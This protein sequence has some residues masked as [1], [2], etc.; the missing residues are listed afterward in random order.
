MD[1][2]W[3]DEG[4]VQQ[5]NI[6][7]GYVWRY[8]YNNRN[9]PAQGLLIDASNNLIW[10]ADYAFDALGNRGSETPTLTA[11]ALPPR[12]WPSS[13]M[14]KTATPADL[15][16][17]GTSLPAVFTLDAVDAFFAKIEPGDSSTMV[18]GSPALRPRHL[19]V[20]RSPERTGLRRLRPHHPQDRPGPDDRYT[21][22]GRAHGH[23]TTR[24]SSARQAHVFRGHPRS[25]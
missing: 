12:P 21:Y 18:D 1:Y 24:C 13:P 5:T 16:A 8:Q 3:D 10:E 17:S 20:D 7:T 6:S 14:T 25:R 2:A 22:T 15:D 9:Q 4:T 23:Y 19:P 11:P